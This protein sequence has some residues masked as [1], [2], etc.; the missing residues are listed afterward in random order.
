MKHLFKCLFVIILALSF[1]STSIPQAKRTFRSEVKGIKEFYSYDRNADGF[2]EIKISSRYE[3][4][5]KVR[6]R[7]YADF[8][9]RS[10]LSSGNVNVGPITIGDINMPMG[11]KNQYSIR[12]ADTAIVQKL[13]TLWGTAINW[14]IGGNDSSG[15]D[16]FNHSMYIPV[17]LNVGVIGLEDS[18]TRQVDINKRSNITVT[19][20]A[21]TLNKKGI[22]IQVLSDSRLGKD[23]Y[24]DTTSNK[25]WEYASNTIVTEDDGSYTL[26][27][28]D[29]RNMPHPYTITILVARKSSADITIQGK[30][31]QLL[32]L[33][34]VAISRFAFKR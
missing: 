25:E 15:F 14:S 11:Y 6:I 12:D 31:I 1:L 10:N 33:E 5:E 17:K 3:K 2:I 7:A 24:I 30:K 32:F 4:Q 26:K 20:N 13:N 8:Y 21:D 16:A 9:N 34:T 28:I 19:W 18:F 22:A 23:G 27:P 29:F